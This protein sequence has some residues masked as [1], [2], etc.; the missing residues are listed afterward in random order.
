M[1]IYTLMNRKALSLFLVVSFV[2][3][4][5]S[6]LFSTQNSSDRYTSAFIA[7]MQAGGIGDALGRVTEFIQSTDLIFKK[8]PH[9]VRSYDD[10]LVDD[11]KYV[12]DELKN[13]GIAPYTDDTGMAK[14]VM[15]ELIYSREHNW[16]LNE[17][18]CHIAISFVEDAKDTK[19]GWIARFR[20]PGNAC[21]AGVRK[22]SMN[23]AENAQVFRKFP[24]AWDV[25]AHTAGGCGS[26]MRAH[27]F[28][29]VF[30]D[31]PEKAAL[32]VVEHSRL[33]HGDPIALAACSA[34]A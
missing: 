16:D 5:S 20:A 34:M 28:G 25:E 13:K 32:W 31:N 30:A 10:F 9:G 12:P 8:Y 11:W 19:L 7:S 26:V 24:P 15:K 3:S 14:L 27:P 2:I 1:N 6:Q 17:T 21:K 22:L 23:F 29:L 18:M 4:P 33:T